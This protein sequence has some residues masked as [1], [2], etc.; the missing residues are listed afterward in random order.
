MPVITFKTQFGK[1]IET[2]TVTEG[3]SGNYITYP[4]AP[5][6]SGY[7]FSHWSP[8]TLKGVDIDEDKTVTAF[9][10]KNTVYYTLTFVTEFG[11]QIT[12][13]QVASGTPWSSVSFPTPNTVTG[14]EFSHWNP[15]QGTS[16]TITGNK[17]I[18][19][20]Y[21]KNQVKCTYTCKDT[22]GNTIDGGTLYYK[23]GAT[24]SVD[25]PGITGYTISGTSSYSGTVGRTD[26]T[27]TFTYTRNK[28]T[29]KFYDLNG[30]LISSATQTVEHGS[31]AAAP[32][33]LVSGYDISWSP[34]FNNVTKDLHVYAKGTP[35]KY[36]VTIKCVDSA[37][38][39]LG[40]TTTAAIYE[41]NTRRSFSAPE[42]TGYTP[43][44]SSETITIQV[45]NVITFQ[46]LKT[47]VKHTVYYRDQGDNDLR[48]P[49]VYTNLT[50]GNSLPIAAPALPGY[51]LNGPSS[52]KITVGASDGSTTFYYAPNKYTITWY[53]NGG[54]F[55]SGGAN[56]QTEIY[57]NGK[58]SLPSEIPEKSDSEFSGWYTSPTGNV[59]VHDGDIYDTVGDST[60]YAQY[61]PLTYYT[62][63]FKDWDGTVLKT[64]TVAK[65]YSA[66][67][68]AD[69]TRD[70]YAFTSWDTDFSNVQGH[71]LVTALYRKLAS[72]TYTFNCVDEN[73]NN[74]GTIIKHLTEDEWYSVEAPT[75]TGY[76]I[77]NSYPTGYAGN[78]GTVDKTFTFYY[79][80]NKYTINWY[81]GVGGKFTDG[82][83]YK[84]TE[85]EYD[86]PIISPNSDTLI[87]PSGHKFD[88]WNNNPSGGGEVFVEGTLA[89]NARGSY[90]AQYAPVVNT[91]EYKI[92]H[93]LQKTD[94]TY[95]TT[96]SETQSGLS[97]TIGDTV[98]DKQKTYTHFVYDAAKSSDTSSGTIKE[99][100]SLVLKYY[101]IR[102]KYDVLFINENTT[103]E[104][105]KVYYEAKPTKPTKD[106]EKKPESNGT[107]KYLFKE[108][109]PA[110]HPVI[111]SKQEDN[112][113]TASYIT[114]PQFV[115]TY[116][117][118]DKETGKPIFGIKKESGLRIHVTADEW[119]ALVK[120][121]KESGVT[122]ETDSVSSGTKISMEAVNP[123][124]EKV[125]VD[126]VDQKTRITAAFFNLLKEGANALRLAFEK[127]KKEQS[128]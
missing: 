80:I 47:G 120:F 54:G 15:S 45:N 56:K 33:L 119:N 25:A 12:D 49:Y 8:A 18:T 52:V 26:I 17:T 30:K 65:G 9:Y 104:T 107:A 41:Y 64:Q 24:Y 101:Y 66:T 55:P 58:I 90:Y 88:H 94:G 31:S 124:A 106:P 113:Y 43:K 75:I 126:M 1:I 111:S 76:T 63:T 20:Y 96:T 60:Y 86:I 37:G 87:P 51:T 4:S 46:Y 97:G 77:N 82:S 71:L 105:Q 118:A 14:Y 110:L 91:A 74:I 116:S 83:T 5:S 73:N 114:V 59:Q 35:K 93:Y 128:K 67:A 81:A 22:N 108:W 103:Y 32:N 38:N 7:T 115:W 29:V 92:E 112:T 62:V 27:I 89:Q 23:E 6:V 95:P 11:G 19:A 79:T 16:G 21:K 39:S 3:A 68:P 48:N 10:T 102:N 69:P 34:P 70:G 28:Y 100:G 72:V 57:Y 61:N 123:V 53:A 40:S 98:K 42:I 99:D 78:A 44:I 122:L 85:T 84:R 127:R 125:G 2:R 117:G 13:F 36:S 109:T 121:V 50:E